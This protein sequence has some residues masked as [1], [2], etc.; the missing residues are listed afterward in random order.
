MALV[1]AVAM[2]ATMVVAMVRRMPRRLRLR[3]EER[4]SAALWRGRGRVAV[5][6]VRIMRFDA[7]LNGN[8][9]EDLTKNTYFLEKNHK[10]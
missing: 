6:I 2:V 3:M 1:R 8:N 5:C 4:V 7:L 10:I 9:D